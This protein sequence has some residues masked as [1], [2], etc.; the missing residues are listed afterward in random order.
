MTGDKLFFAVVDRGKANRLL[1][2]AQEC[3]AR[4]GTIFLGEGT[5]QSR[6]LDKLGLNEVHKEIL[7]TAVA[8]SISDRLYETLTREFRLHRK[9][10]GI[11]FTTPYRRW[12]SQA[13]TLPAIGRA[14]DAP[15]RCLMTVID[16]GRGHDCMEI[17]R[18]AGAGGGTIIHAHGA[19]VPRDYYFPL[20]IEP[21]KDVLMIVTPSAR[22]PTIRSAI[23]TGM[24]LHTR[25]NGI[26]FT[27][28]VLNTVGLYDRPRKEVPQ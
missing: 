6:L 7:M 22:A 17:A 12:S 21:Q 13:S 27:L 20:M 26:I 10:T 18:A 4:G 23:Y 1:R 3:G 25:G 8:D 2:M 24:D 28:P 9:N 19:G 16:K 11:A 14:E 15:Y 5:M